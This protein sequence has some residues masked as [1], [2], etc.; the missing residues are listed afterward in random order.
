MRKLVFWLSLLL[1]FII[2]WENMIVL[3]GLGTISRTLGLSV[4]AFWFVSLLSSGYLRKP[5]P[6]HVFIFLFVYWRLISSFWTIDRESTNISIRTSL[7][8]AVLSWLIWDVYTTP[9][10]LKAGLQAYVLGAYLTIGSIM[11][12]YFTSVYLS[13]GRVSALGFNP[14]DA[15]LIITLGIPL[16]WYLAVSGGGERKLDLALKLMNFAYLPAALL[17]IVLTA[18]RGTLVSALP[19]F[20]FVLGS[21]AQLK[22]FKRVLIFFAFVGIIFAGQSLVP[23]SSLNRLSSTYQSI[24]AADLGGRVYIWDKTVDVYMS[25][26]LLGVGSGAGSVAVTHPIHNSF[27]S[28]LV[29]V[30]LIGFAFFAIAMMIVVRQAIHQPKWMSRL[31]ISVLLI[32]L[33]GNFVHNWEYRKQNW[34]FWNLVVVSAGLSAE[35]DE[36]RLRSKLPVK[37]NDLLKGETDEA[38]DAIPPANRASLGNV[39]GDNSLPFRYETGRGSQHFPYKESKP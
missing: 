24:A 5:H 29:D 22:P 33:L 25:H 9:A 13:S 34:L 23:Q 30:G 3:P 21:F 11:G 36:S 14:N 26:P 32:L 4:A 17:A 18:S 35:C 16:A 1:I 10:A 8:L 27:L 38:N 31:W 28:I 20:L 7:Q 2:P 6:F 39:D 12:N 37:L 15:S 19:G